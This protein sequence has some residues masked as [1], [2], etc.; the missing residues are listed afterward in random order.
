VRWCLIS[1]S[2]LLCLFWIYD[3]HFVL[4]VTCLH[5]AYFCSLCVELW[6]HIVDAL[7][8]Q[9]PPSD[10][11]SCTVCDP[12]EAFCCCIRWNRKYLYKK[13]GSVLR[14][15]L[16]AAEERSQSA[17]WKLWMWTV[18]GPVVLQLYGIFSGLTKTSMRTIKTAVQCNQV[19]YTFGWQ[20][21]H[22][23]RVRFE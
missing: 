12:Y 6:D 9:S 8:T 22:A 3:T 1:W 15:S 4:T 13:I 19:M 18:R 2:C 5:E 7:R 16:K 11:E 21:Q 14:N 10:W 20:V 17:V 23:E